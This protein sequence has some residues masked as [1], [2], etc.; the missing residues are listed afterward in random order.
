MNNTYP[1]AEIVRQHRAET[2][3]T[4]PSLRISSINKAVSFINIRG[5]IYFWPIK[6]ITLPSLWVAAAGDRPVADE[7]DDP[8]HITWNWK[9]SLL[10]KK[11]V[12]YAR[13]LRRKNT[14]ISLEMLP[15]FY[16]LTPNYGDWVTDYLEQYQQGSMT[17][18]AR[19]IYEALLREGPLN[20]IMLRKASR[21]TGEAAAGLFARALDDLM[22]EFKILPVAVSDAGAWHYCHVYDITPRFYPDLQERS[23]PVDEKE[24]RMMILRKYFY[25]VGAASNREVQRLF[26]WLPEIIAETLDT[27]TVAGDLTQYNDLEFDRDPVWVITKLLRP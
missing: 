25:S 12:Y 24:A 4:S 2:F 7:H 27:L 6:G 9:D 26:G 3:C 23:R 16:C 18:P 5:F 11:K 8:G 20:T 17:A 14:F 13:I 15:Y 10:G 19:S 22:I 21:L 1:L